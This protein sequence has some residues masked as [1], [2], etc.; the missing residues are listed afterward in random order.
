MPFKID[1]N[2]IQ[3]SV[4]L[5]NTWGGKDEVVKA[6]FTTTRFGQG[7]EADLS[8]NLYLE[9]GQGRDGRRV[10][11]MTVRLELKICLI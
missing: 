7:G 4:T 9:I 1:V 2:S 8:F 11:N 3:S 10:P 5:E 6:T